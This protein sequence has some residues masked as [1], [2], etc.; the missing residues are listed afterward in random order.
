M[1]AVTIKTEPVDRELIDKHMTQALNAV[2]DGNYTRALRQFEK[3]IRLGDTAATVREAAAQT[4][5][6]ASD[7]QRAAKH[8]L[9]VAKSS[10]RRPGP[11]IQHVTA[12]IRANRLAR[13]E[14][15][16][17]Q[18]E[19]LKAKTHVNLRSSL[20]I[21]VY[22]AQGRPEAAEAI[23]ENASDGT[24][25]ATHALEFAQRF[26]ENRVYAASAR[27]LARAEADPAMRE[28]ALPLRARLHYAEQQWEEA[29]AAFAQLEQIGP[30]RQ[31]EGARIHLA[32]IALHT[33]RDSVAEQRF[34]R[35][36]VDN[37]DHEEALSYFIRA[38][39]GDNDGE[40]ALRLIEEHWSVLDPVRR[41]H[42][43]A[44]A[45][46]MSDPEAALTVYRD[47]TR[48]M[49][50]LLALRLSFA[51]FLLYL[52]KLAD[53]E[54]EINT[55]LDSAPE[56][57]DSNSLFLQ[58]LQKTDAPAPIQLDQ[59]RLTLALAPLDIGLLNTVGNLLARCNRRSEAVRHYRAAVEK[60]PQAAVLW[61]NGTYH[62]MVENQLEEAEAFATRGATTVGG[63]TAE[64]LAN[65]AWILQAAAQ[66]GRALDYIT[67]ALQQ[68]PESVNV[69]TMA[70]DLQMTAGYY[71]DA[72]ALIA[73][74]DML[75]FPRRTERIA[76]AAAQCMAA[77]RAVAAAAVVNGGASVGPLAA[78]GRISPVAGLFP[79]A[80]FHAVVATA[81]PAPVASRQG[82]L[83]FS[84]NLGAG[85]AER[86]VA[87][88]MQGLG[89]DPFP[90]ELAALAVN[91]LDPAN[92][93]D[94]FLS[95]V[96][97]TGCQVIDL[98]AE[99]QRSAIRATLA[100]HPE[101]AGNVRALAALPAELGRMAIPFY[102]HLVVHRPRVVHMWQD[103]INVAGG[104]AA[105]VAG[106]PQIVLCTRSTHPVEIRR[107]RR[108]LRE[109]YHALLKYTG[110]VTIVN[111]SANGARD[112]EEWLGLEPG[113]I[114]VFYNGYDFAALRARRGPDDRLRIRARYAI[115]EEAPVI[116]GVMRFSAEKRPDLWV[117]TVCAA[118]HEHPSVHGLIV[119]DGP[120][121]EDLTALV[122]GRGLAGRIHFVGRHTPVEPWMS[123]MDM[124]FLSSVTEG[125]PNVLIEAQALEVPVATMNVGG[126]PEALAAGESGIVLD[127]APA[128]M[129]AAAILAAM[130]D[131]P[132]MAGMRRAAAG[133]V[134]ARF[135]LPAMVARL[136]GFYERPTE[137]G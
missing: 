99:R 136:K 68:A 44:R 120:M 55:C 33:G 50:E 75:H 78:N 114:Q 89:E 82:I 30:E 67:R 112:Y 105:V 18:H 48:A 25:P 7:W 72:W 11:I 27:W 107:Y 90:G 40:A 96:E 109:G 42:F 22:L 52:N 29:E 63:D 37:P 57:L 74:L 35:V 76:H 98:D 13:A 28:R 8:W 64:R 38:A 71:A 73:R 54:T 15:F 123:A 5:T 132:R 26:F 94:F 20:M 36:L 1:N 61:R 108:Y 93:N 4:A 125:L 115:P 85:G 113:R 69:L 134:N 32:R 103:A 45:V 130:T 119:G 14:A 91:S 83:H 116:G 111:N 9:V 101:H 60:V 43:K 86:Q 127:E 137:P 59:A 6:R 95:E 47:A 16:C 17:R 133:F 87:Y 110:R 129:L 106:V 126:A 92:A 122:K 65:A 53:A 79:E 39:L 84:S 80:L 128:D 135:A 102:A 12:L 104:L 2:Q 70:V 121:R 88:V 10:P 56:D 77:F 24:A 31:A 46:A 66:T 131:A 118:V 117:D 124:L 49:P 23:A 19:L 100:A 58:F 34:H 41:V 21:A 3:C 97:P 51:G 81:N 62:M